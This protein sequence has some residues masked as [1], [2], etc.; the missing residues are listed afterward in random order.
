[1]PAELIE[2]KYSRRNITGY[3]RSVIKLQFRSPFAWEKWFLG[4]ASSHGEFINQGEEVPEWER[5]QHFSPMAQ[6]YQARSTRRY[7]CKY[8]IQY[9]VPKYV[10][11]IDD[12]DDDD[13]PPKKKMRMS[14]RPERIHCEAN[15]TRRVMDDGMIKVRYFWKHMHHDPTS[16]DQIDGVRRRSKITKWI[17]EKYSGFGGW[18]MMGIPVM[19]P[20]KLLDQDTRDMIIRSRLPPHLTTAAEYKR[21]SNVL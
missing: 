16:I 17:N 8:A 1:M 9:S 7:V 20:N 12:D 18:R 3:R 15:I 14:E 11:S 6:I 5:A 21:V 2:S 13:E 19:R 4:T 10:K